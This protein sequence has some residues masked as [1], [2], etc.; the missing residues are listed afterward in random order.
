MRLYILSHLHLEFTPFTPP[1]PNAD[2]VILAGDI[3][4]GIEAIPMI[5]ANFQAVPVVYISGNP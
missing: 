3:D 4:P 2:V 5:Q 1:R